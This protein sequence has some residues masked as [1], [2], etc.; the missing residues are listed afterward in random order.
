MSSA[1]NKIPLHFMIE[2]VY[3]FHICFLQVIN[4]E[5]CDG[6]YVLQ[7]LLVNIMDRFAGGA[8]QPEAFTRVVT[9]SEVIL[10][11]TLKVNIEAV[12]SF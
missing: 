2:K 4:E 11:N 7:Y 6:G 10:P 9:G 12:Q 1:L 3:I 8:K 5:R